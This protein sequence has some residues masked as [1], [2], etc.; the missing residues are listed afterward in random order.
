MMPPMRYHSQCFLK[1]EAVLALA[2]ATFS[3]V[4]FFFLGS[5][6]LAT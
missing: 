2:V 1:C 4:V 5:G 6:L 3:L